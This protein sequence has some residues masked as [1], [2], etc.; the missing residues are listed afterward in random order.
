MPTAWAAMPIRPPSRVAMAILKPSP[1]SPRRREA[2][3]RMPSN[4]SSVVPE[5]LTPSFTSW[6]PWL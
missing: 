1:S 6:S 4:A 3:T 2:G 5:A